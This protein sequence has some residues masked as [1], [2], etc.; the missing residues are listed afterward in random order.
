M[1][2]L[3]FEGVDPSVL[4]VGKDMHAIPRKFQK[5]PIGGM[6]VHRQYWK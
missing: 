6:V 1:H 4:N 3:L 5:L 2:A